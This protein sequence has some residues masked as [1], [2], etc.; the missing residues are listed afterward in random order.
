MVLKRAQESFR[1]GLF[2][3][4]K[5]DEVSVKMSGAGLGFLSK[6]DFTEMDR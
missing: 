6:T 1:S 2:K 4:L 5:S 3:N